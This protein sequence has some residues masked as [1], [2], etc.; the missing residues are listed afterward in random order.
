MASVPRM[1]FDND[2]YGRRVNESTSDGYQL[3]EFINECGREP[4]F[5]MK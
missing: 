5:K 4:C 3:G 2:V 1:S